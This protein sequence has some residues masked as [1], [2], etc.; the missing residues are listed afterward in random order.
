[1]KY[2]NERFYIT[3][4]AVAVGVLIICASYSLNAQP[5]LF[6]TTLPEEKILPLGFDEQ[7]ILSIIKEVGKPY[8]DTIIVMVLVCDT[9]IETNNMSSIYD[10]HNPHVWW[11]KAYD[12]GELHNTSEGVNDWGICPDCYHDYYRH[13]KFLSLDKQPIKKQYFVWQSYPQRKE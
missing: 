6:K 12:V 10:Q 9:A 1:M 5:N 13:I 7:G 4:L 11:A 3:L 8:H 2:F